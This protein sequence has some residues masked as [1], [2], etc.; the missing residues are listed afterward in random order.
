MSI[1]ETTSLLKLVETSSQSLVTFA[2]GQL[3]VEDSGDVYYDPTTGTT[4]ADRVKLVD[5]L[6]LL[7][8]QNIVDQSLTT[9]VKSIPGAINELAEILQDDIISKIGVSNGIATLDNNSKVPMDQLPDAIIGSVVYKGAWDATTGTSEDSVAIPE[10]AAA[11]KGYYYITSV[12]GTWNGMTFEGGDWLISDGSNWSKV[13]TSCAVS[14][15]NSKVGN[16]II[17]AND[18]GLGNVTNESKTTMFTDPTFTGVVTVP[19]LE[20]TDI[21]TKAASTE[22]VSKFYQDA[23]TQI[24]LQTVLTNSSVYS[25]DKEVR[26]TS[27]AGHILYLHPLNLK[28]QYKAAEDTYFTTLIDPSEAGID[29]TTTGWHSIYQAYGISLSQID[30]GTGE[31]QLSFGINAGGTVQGSDYAKGSFNT[32]LGNTVQRITA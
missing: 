1:S 10:A 12:P 5:Q 27:S 3:I 17:T 7:S 6:A 13:D 32:W 16:V 26:M 4:V 2:S 14:S 25:G 18:V 8:K 9:S 11:N 22:F 30:S 23:A 21:S 15:V 19:T 29:C 20:I 28:M 31:E 24:T